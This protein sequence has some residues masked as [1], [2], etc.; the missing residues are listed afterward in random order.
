MTCP[1]TRTACLTECSLF[2]NN[3]CLLRAY[4]INK[5]AETDLDIEER[6]LRLGQEILNLRVN[7]SLEAE[8]R[9]FL[10][11]VL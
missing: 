4:L 1:F 8:R 9:A 5:I 3:K 10:E 2:K 6:K 7:E 11:T